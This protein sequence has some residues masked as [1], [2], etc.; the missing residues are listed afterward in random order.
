ML[1]V[2]TSAHEK[3]IASVDPG[4]STIVIKAIDVGAIKTVDPGAENNDCHRGSSQLL[5]AD[6]IAFSCKSELKLTVDSL[7]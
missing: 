2:I 6:A 1:I 3:V 5:C 4:G 7:C